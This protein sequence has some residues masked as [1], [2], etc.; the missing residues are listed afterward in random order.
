MKKNPITIGFDDAQFKLKSGSNTTQL[1]GVIC[2]GI[3][4]VNVVK[5]EILIDGNNA[6]AKLIEL[7]KKNKKYVQI[8]ITH[9]I[10]FGGFNIINLKQIYEELNKPI[11]AINDRKV[12][13]NGVKEA[14]RKKFSS[15]YRE[16]IQY[17]INAGNLYHSEIKT[18]GG[19]SKVYFHSKG[20]DVS[21]IES[22]LPKICI[23]SKFPECIRLAHLIGTL[24]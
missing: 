21:Y 11:I 16:K 12:D 18:A 2:Q 14:L 19:V 22:L 7:V 1:I 23:D 3:R 17:I 15:E 20:V 10:T 24:F 13:L 8:I 4:M 6:T 9:S 5:T